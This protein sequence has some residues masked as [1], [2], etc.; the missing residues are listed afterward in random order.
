LTTVVHERMRKM[1]VTPP[2][3]KRIGGLACFVFLAAMQ[4]SCMRHHDSPAGIGSS[5]PD[6]A[7]VAIRKNANGAPAALYYD[8]GR[9]SGFGRDSFDIFDGTDDYVRWIGNT[10]KRTA[11]LDTPLADKRLF[12]M[13]RQEGAE[14][15]AQKSGIDRSLLERFARVYR[16]G[17]PRVLSHPLPIVSP[18][19]PEFQR[20]YQKLPDEKVAGRMCVVF[21]ARDASGDKIWVEPTT[22]CVLRQHKTE[23][24]GNP[25]IPPSVWDW[26]VSRFTQVPSVEPKHFQIP[27][28]VT[29]TLPRILSDLPLPPGVHRKLLTGKNSYTG[30]DIGRLVGYLERRSRDQKSLRSRTIL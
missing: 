20:A 24:S 8:R 21:L 19:A 13:I 7:Y 11:E 10:Q 25:R 12:D 26:E 6:I 2:L 9:Y 16:P 14:I 18:G 27:S 15:A 3:I 28:G 17:R 4:L 23:A 5:N 1:K 22:H 30:S 29:V